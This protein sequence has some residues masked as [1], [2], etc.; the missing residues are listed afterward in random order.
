MLCCESERLFF[1]SSFS[2]LSQGFFTTRFGFGVA[3]FQK[4][5]FV[6]VINPTYFYSN[7]CICLKISK[8]LNIKKKKKV[9]NTIVKMAPLCSMEDIKKY[10]QSASASRN[11][12]DV[13]QHL[14]LGAELP[15]QFTTNQLQTCLQPHVRHLQ[16]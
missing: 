8:Q 2:F 5:V 3:S 13:L 9:F 15:R 12:I 16:I 7:P 4:V 11:S 10:S 1:L 14:I 6:C